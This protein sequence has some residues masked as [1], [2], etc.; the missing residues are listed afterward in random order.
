AF[1]TDL[2]EAAKTE[3]DGIYQRAAPVTLCRMDDHVGGFVDDRQKLVLEK[4]VQGNVFRNRQIVRWFRQLDADVVVITHFVACLRRFPIHG[5]GLR[6][7]GF[8]DY[9]P[10]VFRE[11]GDQIL[12]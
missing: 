7:D 10:A 1:A 4:N 3:L 5:N 12:V 6:V 2:T 11:E 8:L 9:R